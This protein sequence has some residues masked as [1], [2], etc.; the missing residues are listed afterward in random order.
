MKRKAPKSEPRHAQDSATD[1]WIEAAGR[2]ARIEAVDPKAVMRFMINAIYR[3]PVDPSDMKHAAMLLFELMQGV[4]DGDN[5]G[6]Q[7][8][9]L[10]KVRKLRANKFN[11]ATADRGSPAWGIVE[12]YVRGEIR[13]AEAVY[14]FGELHPASTRQCEAWIQTMKPRVQQTMDFLNA[15]RAE[16]NS[17][18]KK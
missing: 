6:T 8:R 2:Q 9:R 18:E 1:D 14:Q 7:F 16:D 17:T 10:M 4:E 12:Q 15:L 5:V 3:R 11:P 13:H